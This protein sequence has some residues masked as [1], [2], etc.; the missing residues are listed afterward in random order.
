ML[1]TAL[2]IIIFLV[3]ALLVFAST[4]SDKFQ[5][6]RKATI[7][8]TPDIIFACINDLQKWKLWSP[9]ETKD[10][11]MK[12]TFGKITVGK[13]AVYEWDGNKNVGRGR[14]EI[15]ESTPPFHLTIKLDFISP[16][17]AHNIVE[18]TLV[19]RGSSTE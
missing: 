5:V 8:A 4:R 19:A 2:Y 9:W 12:K 13:D 6:R 10:L 16:F 14:M 1:T 18:F 11:A 7:N 3:I 15:T 17:K